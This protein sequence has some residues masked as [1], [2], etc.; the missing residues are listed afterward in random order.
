LK[1]LITFEFPSF[2]EILI[3]LAP[4]CPQSASKALSEACPAKR[5]EEAVSQADCFVNFY[6][7]ICCT[8]HDG[9]K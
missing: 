4:S 6:D 2:A 7:S 3:T 8:M 1:D 5:F 9:R